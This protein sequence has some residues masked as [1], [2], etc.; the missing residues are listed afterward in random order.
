MKKMILNFG[1]SL[2]SRDQM[3]KIKGGNDSADDAP[4]NCRS[5]CNNNE[6]CASGGPNGCIMCAS[7]K[8]V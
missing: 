3:K 4:N 6:D 2:L 8:C 1:S 7:F 5:N